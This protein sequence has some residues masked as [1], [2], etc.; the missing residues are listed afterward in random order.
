[1][2]SALQFRHFSFCLKFRSSRPSSPSLIKNR[3]GS[4]LKYSGMSAWIKW[5]NWDNGR[6]WAKQ[7]S[8]FLISKSMLTREATYIK[9]FCA[10]KCGTLITVSI[11]NDL[12][13]WINFQFSSHSEECRGKKEACF[14]NA[15]FIVLNHDLLKPLVFSALG[16]FVFL[17]LLLHR[18]HYSHYSTITMATNKVRR[19]KKQKNAYKIRTVV[20]YV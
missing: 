14:Y 10:L 16:Y 12:P 13:F 20:K 2:E 11:E 3:I 1:M 6:R 8:S 17:L 15:F 18:H 5:I 7:H 9:W 19:M 4:K